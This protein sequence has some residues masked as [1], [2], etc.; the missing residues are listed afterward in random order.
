[1][2]NIDEVLK[3]CINEIIETAEEAK[4]LP[5][6]ANGFKDGKLLAYNEILSMFQIKLMTVS[7]DAP[8]EFGLDFDIDK[9]LA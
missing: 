1:M 9:K 4:N 7:P 3:E 6:D 2:D 5:P 8:D